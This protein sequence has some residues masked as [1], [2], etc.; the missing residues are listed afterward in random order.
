MWEIHKSGSVRGIETPCVA[1]KYETVNDRSHI[2]ST[3]QKVIFFSILILG[4]LLVGIGVVTK[5]KIEG[6]GKKH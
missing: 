1:L 5:R 2:M 6:A 4:V 3:R